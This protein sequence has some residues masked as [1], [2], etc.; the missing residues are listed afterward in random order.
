MTDP[1]VLLPGEDAEV[2]HCAGTTAD[3]TACHAPA[4]IL[5]YDEESGEFW[6]I[7][8]TPDATMRER[9]RLGTTRGGLTSKMRLS[10]RRG[11]AP[12]QLGKPT[13]ADEIQ[14]TINRVNDWVATG[15]LMPAQGNTILRGLELSLQA[16]DLA[17]LLDLA[18]QQ[19]WLP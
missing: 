11:L 4:A 15:Q 5:H 14:A 7:G 13:T 19:E 1:T 8:H 10:K 12:G 3:G 17:K 6:C 9:H 18:K 16:G 2:P